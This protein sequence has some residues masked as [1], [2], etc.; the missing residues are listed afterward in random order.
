MEQCLLHVVS[1]EVLRAT[2]SGKARSAKVH[3]QSKGAE[4]G[5][6]SLQNHSKKYPAQFLFQNPCFNDLGYA[7]MQDA[8][9]AYIFHQNEKMA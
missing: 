1:E 3:L 5:A 6:C 4:L 8:Q 2:S 9:T 7:H